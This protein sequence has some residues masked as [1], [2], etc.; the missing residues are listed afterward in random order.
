MKTE[1]KNL[2][3][4]HGVKKEIATD[5]VLLGLI[6]EF[7]ETYASQDKWISVKERLPEINENVICSHAKDGWVVCGY[8]A[9]HGIWYNQFQDGFSDTDIIVTHW[10]PLPTP[11]KK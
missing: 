8:L 1:L 5:K 3:L 9:P 11:P 4:K 10:Q 6:T 2:L 7:I